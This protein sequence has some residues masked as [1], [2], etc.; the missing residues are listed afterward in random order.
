[1]SF[2]GVISIVP[3]TEEWL[4]WAASDGIKI[5]Q[6][7]VCSDGEK[8]Q[9]TDICGDVKSVSYKYLGNGYIEQLTF[10]MFESR[11]RVGLFTLIVDAGQEKA[12]AQIKFIHEKGMKPGKE[13]GIVLAAAFEAQLDGLFDTLVGAEEWLAKHKETK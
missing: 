10:R 8:I 9:I 4:D 13:M 1:M 2:S 5:G 11:K 6:I 7:Y 3:T 12:A